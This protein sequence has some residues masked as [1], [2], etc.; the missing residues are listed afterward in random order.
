MVSWVYMNDTLACIQP[1]CIRL[2]TSQWMDSYE[3]CFLSGVSLFH[4]CFQL[5]CFKT[6][7]CRCHACC[8]VVPAADLPV[9]M[10]HIISH[11]IPCLRACAVAVRKAVCCMCY[12]HGEVRSLLQYTSEGCHDRGSLIIRHR[13]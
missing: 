11:V 5:E 2:Q 7:Y 3:D 12:C 8:W 6:Y 10:C 9:C 1:V 13:S 4:V